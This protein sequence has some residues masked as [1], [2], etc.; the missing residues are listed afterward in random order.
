MRT[1]RIGM[2]GCGVVGQGVVKLLKKHQPDFQRN[3]FDLKLTQVA[4]KHLGKH[5]EVDLHGVRVCQDP[6][7]VAKDP[8]IDLLVEVMGGREVAMEA[9][10]AALSRGIPV[11]S[12]N[13]A[14]LA[15]GLSRYLEAAAGSG[16]ALG[17]EAACAAHI[18][19]IEA[20][21]RSLACEEITLVK[22]VVNGTTNYILTLMERTGF[23]FAE[24]LADATAKGFTEADPSLDVD[25]IDAAEKLT[26][27]VF[28][29]F[30]QYVPP[31][32]IHTE[33]I[34]RVTRADML[35]SQALNHRVKLIAGAR[36]V[37]GKLNCSVHPALI[38][39]GELL[40]DVDSEFNAIILEGPAFKELTFMG[41]GAGQLPTAS[42]VLNDI[43]KFARGGRGAA[44]PGFVKAPAA[45][46]AQA[47]TKHLAY[48]YFLR[49]KILSS[50]IVDG[51]VSF[52]ETQNV[53]VLS[54]AYISDGEGDYLGLITDVVK[55]SRLSHLMA[56]LRR[57]DGVLEEPAFIR[58]DKDNYR[59]IVEHEQRAYFGASLERQSGPRV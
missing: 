20:L 6:L 35:L 1:I 41:K 12:A 2:L 5:R 46:L 45:P 57:V 4:V 3:G 26:L 17:F 58:L 32:Q 34:S 21:D 11:V 37:D 27:L 8:D 22:G 38:H 51:V 47:P 36:V 42:A 28:K 52:L 54:K 53:K 56:T 10:L 9:G 29:A 18:P 59:D 39:R 48:C 40:A 44:L 49:L 55:E 33:G 7:A 15:R 30:G 13:K 16:A 25:G 23:S 50:G 43:V 19:I 14:A 24:A 31:E